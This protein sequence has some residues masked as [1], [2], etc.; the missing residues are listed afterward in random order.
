MPAI[1]VNWYEAIAY[2]NW[3]S[4]KRNYTPVYQIEG[5]Q[6]IPDWSANGY[7]L[8]TEAE[9]EYAARSG[10]KLEK[11][12]GTSAAD[13]L[14]IY[15]NIDSPEDSYFYRSPVG[16]FRG[17]GLGFVDMTGNVWEWCWDWYAA[18]YYSFSPR[19][20]PK[21]PESGTSRVLRGGCWACRKIY[22][23]TAHRGRQWP[24]NGINHNGFRIARNFGK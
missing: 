13:S 8:P 19:C 1:Y 23:T 7:R 24:E 22:S 5:K 4:E 2:C 3:L 12:S 17:N 20:N 14:S 18:D 9:W 21:G 11:W 10:G 6:V 16:S 15:A